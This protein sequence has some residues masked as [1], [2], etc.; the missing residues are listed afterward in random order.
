[1][2]VGERIKLRGPKGEIVPAW[3]SPPNLETDAA[4]YSYLAVGIQPNT[5]YSILLDSEDYRVTTTRPLRFK[6][7]NGKIAYSGSFHAARE[8]EDA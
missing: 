4:E 1:M 3:L 6:K 2:E 8:N 7:E 5:N